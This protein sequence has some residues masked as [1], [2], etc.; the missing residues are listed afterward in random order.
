MKHTFDEMKKSWLV[1]LPW[2][3][4]TLL[5]GCESDGQE[6]AESGFEY[7]YMGTFDCLLHYGNFLY[8]EN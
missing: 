2:M 6:G 1:L 8:V 5:V 7:R 3:L 4:L